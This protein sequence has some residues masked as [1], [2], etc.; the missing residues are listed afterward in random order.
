MR[1]SRLGRSVECQSRGTI[2]IRE[3]FVFSEVCDSC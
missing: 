2:A 3:V 1:G